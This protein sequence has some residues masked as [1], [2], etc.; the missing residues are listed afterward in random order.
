MMKKNTQLLKLTL[1]AMFMAIGLLLPFLTGQIPEIGKMLLPMHIPVFLC[2]MICGWQYGVP[3]AVVLP[4]LRGLLF[5]MPVLYP[6]AIGMAFE[7]AAYAFVA[8][9]LFARFRRR[10]AGAVY[11]SMLPA[12]I[13]G[14]LVWGAA[15]W[16]LLGLAGNA[17]TL[18]LFW[19]GAFLNAVPG[20]V[21]QLILIPAVM[22]V[23][24][25][26]TLIPLDK[27][28]AADGQAAD[29]NG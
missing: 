14:R 3:L 29:S 12:M 8:G 28:S 6:N 23:L 19:A 22:A 1:T 4:I 15:Q 18:R 2:A 17:F 16:A 11:G 25:R 24:V 20:I 26:T 5:G 10:G 7:M 27:P 9:F 13:V 21:L